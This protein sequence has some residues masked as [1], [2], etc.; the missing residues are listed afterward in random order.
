MI[1]I[2][3]IWFGADRVGSGWVGSRRLGSSRA[4]LG[5]VRSG[6]VGLGRIGLERVPMENDHPST[7]RSLTQMSCRCRGAH[8]AG[9]PRALNS[10]EE[11]V[12]LC[13]RE[14]LP[15]RGRI[16]QV[17]APPHL[18]P[19]DILGAPRD[20]LRAVPRVAR[21]LSMA[22]WPAASPMPSTFSIARSSARQWAIIFGMARVV[23]VVLP[24]P[25]ASAASWALVMRRGSLC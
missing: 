15:R 19:T 11:G 8:A 23:S 9:L 7:V 25:E 10:P 6:P 4:G 22:W 3:S 21:R 14:A 16:D 20:R 18:R 5:R 24:R 13:H 12:V 2:G 1:S 17:H